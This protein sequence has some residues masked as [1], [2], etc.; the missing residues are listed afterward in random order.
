M[1][2]TTVARK[3]RRRA[4]GGVGVLAA[5]DLSC[6][7]S[8]TT[9]A[10]SATRSR[11]RARN[12][13][14]SSLSGPSSTI[15]PAQSRARSRPRAGNVGPSALSGPS[16]SAMAAQSAT[17]SRMRARNVG[18]RPVAS[19]SV[20]EPSD[21]IPD[22]KDMQ[23]AAR[24]EMQVVASLSDITSAD[25]L[26][27]VEHVTEVD[28]ETRGR[29]TKILLHDPSPPEIEVTLWEEIGS[30]VDLQ[31]LTV[32][33]HVV[34]VAITALKVTRHPGK[35]D[36]ATGTATVTMFRSVVVSMLGVSCYDM[37]HDHG[38]ND[39]RKMSAQMNLMKGVTKIFQLEK[40]KL[41]HTGLRFAVNKVFVAAS[42]AAIMHT[43]PPEK[44]PG[45]ASSSGSKEA[46]AITSLI[47]TKERKALFN[48]QVFWW[49]FC[50]VKSELQDTSYVC[51]FIF[52]LLKLTEH[53]AVVKAI[54]WSPHQ[55]NLLVS[56]G[57]TADRCICFCNTASGN[58][59]NYVDTRSQVCNLAWSKNLN[60]LVSTHGYSQNQIMMW[61]YPT[62]AKVATLTG[63]TIWAQSGGMDQCA[64]AAI[65]EITTFSDRYA[66]FEK[67]NT[68]ILGIS[69]DSVEIESLR[70][71]LGDE[72]DKD[73]QAMSYEELRAGL[74][75][76]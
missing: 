61:K 16:S 17:R 34:I 15:T 2:D 58:Q 27:K 51:I 48:R 19:A 9:P 52:P 49:D 31:A 53:T 37:I 64:M 10:Q 20:P 5:S 14:G 36:D 38:N 68:E 6:P 1:A 24:E 4:L 42:R 59:L 41:D 25:Y 70:S 71:L 40:G 76:R 18:R 32:T 29:L 66:E 11:M 46:S 56:G 62:L 74:H 47:Q 28:T 13:V 8:S 44:G 30:R 23:V 57:G 73:M 22:P 26:G 60:E 54:A 33:D 72:E 7:S 55:S 75:N 35:I 65:V 21:P 3:R 67:L 39:N 43:T 45:M 12:V 50:Y 69:V 63:H